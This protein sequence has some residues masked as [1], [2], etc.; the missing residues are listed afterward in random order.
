VQVSEELSTRKIYRV[1][2]PVVAKK[3][4]VVTKKAVVKKEPAL[5][6]SRAAPI[7]GRAASKKLAAAAKLKVYRAQLQELICRENRLH[8]LGA[9]AAKIA[10]DTHGF[11]VS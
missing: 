7:T 8:L 2:K 3:P 4:P 9:V 10:R 1:K 5:K 11:M 6:L